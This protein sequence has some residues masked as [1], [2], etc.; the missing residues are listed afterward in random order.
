MSLDADGDLALDALG[1]PYLISGLAAVEQL[2]RIAM[3]TIR[4]EWFLDLDVGIP[5]LERDEVPA[6]EALLGQKYDA[7]KTRTAFLEAL[8]AVPGVFEVLELTVDFDGAT[9]ALT[10]AWRTR[11]VFGDTEL[12]TLMM[13]A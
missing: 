3:Q 4:G 6:S 13:G 12:D 2:C 10:V 8:I 9:R 7:I 1:S 11:T 5:Y